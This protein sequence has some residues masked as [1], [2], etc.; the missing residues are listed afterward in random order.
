MSGARPS[1][2]RSAVRST[3]R[4]SDVRRERVAFADRSSFDASGDFRDRFRV[5][6]DPIYRPSASA[7]TGLESDRVVLQFI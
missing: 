6:F 1:D 5:F 7:A 4:D 2:D 3:V